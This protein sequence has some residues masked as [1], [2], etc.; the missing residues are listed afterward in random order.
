MLQSAK[1][2]IRNMNFDYV[3]TTY[4]YLLSLWVDTKAPPATRDPTHLENYVSLRTLYLG[5]EYGV[6]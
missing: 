5:L 4:S 3:T 1:C 2:T 6:L